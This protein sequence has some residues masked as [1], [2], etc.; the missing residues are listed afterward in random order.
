MGRALTV[1]INAPAGGIIQNQPHDMIDPRAWVDGLNIRF[2][3]GGVQTS[4]GWAK[5]IE[6]G[7]AAD[8][9]S[10]VRAI[11]QL[12]KYD[13][14]N[15]LVVVTNNKAWLYDDTNDEFDDISGA[16][17]F[18]TDA[19]NH[20][21][22]ETAFET[23]MI[24]ND[25]DRIQK[26]TGSGN[27]ADLGGLNTSVDET[28]AG[29]VDVEAARSIGAFS[30][31]IHIVNTTEDG[32]RFAQRWR[33]SAFR[34]IEKWN[35][36]GTY[37]QAGFEDVTDGQDTLQC[38]RRLGGDY[39]V[40]YKDKSVH[41]AQYVGPPTVWARR[42]VSTTVGLLAPGA[43]ADIGTIHVFVGND[44]IY[45]F[46]GS[47][48]KPIGDPIWDFFI[49]NLNPNCR[50][51]VY[52]YP[53]FD[54]NEV[55]ICYPH[56]DSEECNRA[57]VYNWLD[58]TWAPREMPFLAMGSY[59]AI[60]TGDSWDESDGTWD[61][62]TQQWN[63][64]STSLNQA[65]ILAGSETGEIYRYGTGWNQDG[66]E[67]DSWVKS[68]AFDMNRPDIVKRLVR[69][70]LDMAVTGVHYANIYYAATDNKNAPVTFVQFLPI[71]CD[72]TGHPWVN[73]DI[74]GRYIR[75]MIRTTG[76]EHPWRCN[77]YG[78]EYLERGRY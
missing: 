46:N 29:T 58:G 48:M 6:D 60:D 69:L 7:V 65:I 59:F 62:D 55:V 21:E 15:F 61:E 73:P 13:L 20:V 36:T 63:F 75:F 28:G 24:T 67:H 32:S 68:K 31:F 71:K 23:L 70:F 8:L 34:D 44:N 56:G 2:T 72:A 5:Y 26:Y 49:N 57:L 3:N 74:S 43:V 45:A 47:T 51:K 76:I 64:S 12:T 66:A 37:G 27:I 30:G 41:L 38:F 54:E 40:L 53:I 11:S 17:S 33:W 39:G 22:T 4:P 14:T 35:N 78:A 52:A 25:R 19:D 42:V 16:F 9:A 1:K 18:T 50:H 10:P 77:G